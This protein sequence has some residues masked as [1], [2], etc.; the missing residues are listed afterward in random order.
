MWYMWLSIRECEELNSVAY[1]TW[2]IEI[3]LPS[4]AMTWSTLWIVLSNLA[5]S[6]LVW[7][8]GLL[9]SS[10]TNYYQL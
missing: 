6:S 5:C 10:C 4:P 9:L 2:E 7:N 1:L 3:V 8:D